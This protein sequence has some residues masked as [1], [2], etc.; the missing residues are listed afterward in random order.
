MV[1]VK[2]L[3]KAEVIVRKMVA[4]MV[5]G[6]IKGVVIHNLPWWNS[7]TGFRAAKRVSSIGALLTIS[8][9]LVSPPHLAEAFFQSQPPTVKNVSFQD[10]FGVKHSLFEPKR[11]ATVIFFIAHDCPVANSY[12]PEMNR[13]AVKYGRSGMA[14]F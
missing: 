8:A 5:S 6:R 10:L 14:F 1:T 12:V 2:S 9:A 7:K 11:K 13:I 4:A 3:A